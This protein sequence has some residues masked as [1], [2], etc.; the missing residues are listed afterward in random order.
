MCVALPR[1]ECDGDVGNLSTRTLPHLL[2]PHCLMVG[3]VS[4]ATQG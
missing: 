2:C 1:V 4:P 3:E